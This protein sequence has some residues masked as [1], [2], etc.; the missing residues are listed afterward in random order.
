MS[1]NAFMLPA[2]PQAP[3][4]GLNGPRQVGSADG[5]TSRPDESTAGG[6]SFMATLNQ[7]SNNRCDRSRETTR[8]ENAGG[9]ADH[10]DAS[11]IP[12]ETNKPVKNP[13]VG[14]E[15]TGISE[16]DAPATCIHPLH[17]LG[18]I[19][20]Q[21]FNFLMSANGSFAVQDHPDSS[22]ATTL[23][24]F[25]NLGAPVLSEGQAIQNGQVG[26]GLFEQ[27]Q[28]NV[29]PD[30]TQLYFFEQ[31]VS[32]AFNHQN[33]AGPLGMQ[34]HFWGYGSWMATLSAG[35]L[36]AP[37]DT[38][39]F[40]ANP[41]LMHLLQVQGVDTTVSEL[42]GQSDGLGE[43]KLTAQATTMDLN[44]EWLLKASAPSQ[45]NGSD[46]SK[47]ALTTSAGNTQSGQFSSLAAGIQDSGITVETKFQQAAENSQM[48]RP[49]AIEKPAD[50]P[51]N[52]KFAA[53]AAVAKPIEESLNLKGTVLKN[54][55]PLAA[56]VVD[57]VVQIEGE[58]KDSNL[59]YGQDHMSERL[60]RF[61]TAS[62]A[63]NSTQRSLSSQA[64]NQIVQRAVLSFRNGQNEVRID[65]KPEFL[66]HIRMQ[67][68]T[69]SQQV[70]VKIMAENPFV[71]DMLDSNLN[72][73]KADLQAQGLKVNELE[74]SVA[75]DSHN[76][77]HNQTTADATKSSALREDTDSDP[78]DVE[79]QIESHVDVSES[80]AE[81]TIDY[82]A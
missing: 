6:Q 39:G 67:I 17:A 25:G 72:Q 47:N 30:A 76:G 65:L 11:I 29:S 60:A 7:V 31:L 52:S 70:A 32:G 1:F 15:N 77:T 58:N 78:D 41:M 73:L 49:Q 74:V 23:L 10:S 75:H 18:L 26:I 13:Q 62:S 44:G 61:E 12:G 64:M 69:E 46:I 20:Q 79:E 68:V 14:G 66:G 81:N 33:S 55:M 21:F 36:N 22:A 53:E 63:S 80:L 34:T 9:N 5:Q 42:A 28:A 16:S 48:D 27:L 35:N 24:E 71:K 82:F 4:A 2:F 40:H 8:I 57:K 59:L 43:Q 19:Q 50:Q 3:A 56:E 51:A 54:Q 45:Q 37:S 38:L